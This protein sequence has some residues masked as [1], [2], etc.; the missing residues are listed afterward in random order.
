MELSKNLHC[1][2]CNSKEFEIKRKVTYIYTYKINIDSNDENLDKTEE[3]PFLFDNREKTE[4]KEY[5]LC[6]TCKNKYPINLEEEG[7]KINF[8]ILRKAIRADHIENPEFLG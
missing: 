4:S 6:K 5:L 7:S 8:T 2:R 1:P 3:L